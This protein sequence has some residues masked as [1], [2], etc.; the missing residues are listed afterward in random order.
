M[1]KSFPL[2]SG[3][4]GPHLDHIRNAGI[5]QSVLVGCRT[6]EERSVM[7]GLCGTG[8]SLMKTVEG[9]TAL[10]SSFST[11]GLKLPF[12]NFHHR[13]SCV[14]LNNAPEA[15]LGRGAWGPL[16]GGAYSVARFQN[17]STDSAFKRRRPALELEKTQKFKM[18]ESFCRIYLRVHIVL[19]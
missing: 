6:R 12:Y 11:S 5:Y 17:D 15:G 18:L 4:A 1:E 16:W 10:I 8:P 3:L 9:G 7:W 14:F 13:S 2:S 19:V